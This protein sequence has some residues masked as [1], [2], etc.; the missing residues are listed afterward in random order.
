MNY[1]LTQAQAQAIVEA[2]EIQSAVE[3]EGTLI[4]ENNPELYDAYLQILLIAEN[5]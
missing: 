4:E 2:H 1:K 5:G 3:Q